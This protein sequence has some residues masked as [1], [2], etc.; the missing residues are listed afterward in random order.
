MRGSEIVTTSETIG[1]VIVESGVSEIAVMTDGFERPDT[2]LKIQNVRAQSGAALQFRVDDPNEIIELAD[3]DLRNGI[4]G[5]WAVYGRSSRPN[6]FASV[7]VDGRVVAAQ[8]VLPL[9]IDINGASSTDN[10]YMNWDIPQVVNADARIN[11]FRT[12]NFADLNLNQNTL[13]IVSGGLL[14][15]DTLLIHDGT[16]TAGGEEP[17]DLMIHAYGN[18]QIPAVITD[19]ASNPVSLNVVGNGEVHLS[20]NNSYSGPTRVGNFGQ[21]FAENV[22]SIPA[23]GN[24]LIDT[25]SFIVDFDNSGDP[26][27]LGVVVLQGDGSLEGQSGSPIEA[28]DMELRSGFLRTELVGSGTLTKRGVDEVIVETSSPRFAGPIVVEQGQLTLVNNSAFGSGSGDPLSIIVNDGG[29]LSGSSFDNQRRI[30]LDGGGALR[31]GDSTAQVEI[32]ESGLIQPRDV[33]SNMTIGGSIVGNGLLTIEATTTDPSNLSM[34]LRA[35]TGDVDIRGNVA[36]IR[37]GNADYDGTFNLYA[38]ETILETPSGFGSG[39]V[40]V[41][42][43]ATLTLDDSISD[44]PIELLGGTLRPHREPA[45]VASPVVVRNKSFI[46][47]PLTSF[48]DTPIH[49]TM[50]FLEPVTFADGS[51]LKIVGPGTVV[52]QGDWVFEGHSKLTSW[53]GERH[54]TGDII[55]TGAEVSI[56]FVGNDVFQQTGSIHVSDGTTLSWLRN[57]IPETLIV[58]E[59]STLTG[60]GAINGVAAID[61]GGTISPADAVAIGTMTAD[62]LHLSAGS[63]Y[64]WGINAADGEAGGQV[65]W[66]LIQLSDGLRVDASAAVPIVLQLVSLA[67]DGSVGSLAGFD[68]ESAF[69]W[70]VIE[71]PTMSG[72]ERGAI[73]VD[74]NVFHVENPSSRSGR[75]AVRERDG[76]LVLGYVP[77]RCGD[78]DFDGDVDTADRTIQAQG[79]TGALMEVGTARFVDGDCDGDGDVDVA[80]VNGLVT[81]WT[82]ARPAS[83]ELEEMGVP[84]DPIERATMIFPEI[85][86]LTVGHEVRAAVVPEP[87]GR[88]FFLLTI[89]FLCRCRSYRQNARWI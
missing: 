10:V 77:Q 63:R 42:D 33:R 44:T 22:E 3:A 76:D 1:S 48:R 41:H 69:E 49:T 20:G 52:F 47:V 51:N 32:D 27:P 14:V 19:N 35:F 43:H 82:G 73:L 60:S 36:R 86:P 85:E 57:G 70:T 58:G 18:V 39:E 30:V 88:R 50:T 8:D 16:L 78:F 26:I 7:D 15:N 38:T 37:R 64:T 71:A 6:D 80:D 61:H 45:I 2:S 25:G 5:G 21:L 24:V 83:L 9:V 89:P 53:R 56:D 87:S 40:F 68:H 46:D 59:Y 72:L 66:D 74:A 62:T 17:A 34:D 54:V 28:S 13:N 31:T 4:L 29:I 79:W 81:H 67:P 11:S 12:E 75:F 84:P 23:H 65:G 55:T